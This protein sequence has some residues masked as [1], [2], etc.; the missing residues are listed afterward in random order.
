MPRHTHNKRSQRRST[1]TP[2]RGGGSRRRP[3]SQDI[4]A[5]VLALR[6][7]GSSY[8]AIARRLEL[9]RATDAHQ[10]FVRA[11]GSRHGDDRRQLIENEEARLDLLE[12]RI[13]DR[14]AADVTKV[15]RRLVGVS[16]LREAIQW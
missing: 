6:E 2:E 9:G 7:S 10:S 5:Q 15:E 12:R 16:K 13:R 11:L 8:S 4:D 3:A 14:D 1:T